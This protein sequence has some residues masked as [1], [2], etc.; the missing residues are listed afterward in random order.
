[1][2]CFLLVLFIVSSYNYIEESWTFLL[3]LC[4]GNNVL[5][6]SEYVFTTN[7]KLQSDVFTWVLIIEYT[8][9]F[10]NWSAVHLSFVVQLLHLLSVVGSV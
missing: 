6:M 2:Y 9:K 7:I 1:V 5:I 10:L 8:K 3:P 4:V